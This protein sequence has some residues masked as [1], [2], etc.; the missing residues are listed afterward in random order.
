VAQDWYAELDGVTA[1]PFEVARLRELAAEG[2]LTGETRVRLRDGEWT[3]AARVSGLLDGGEPPAAA[4]ET[5]SRASIA[6]DPSLN[7][8]REW[9]MLSETAKTADVRDPGRDRPLPRRV[10][11]RGGE[12]ADAPPASR[13]VLTLAVAGLALAAAV[14]LGVWALSG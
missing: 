4:A 6:I 8:T 14:A 5:G 12:P 13:T 1:G 9:R 10:A 7:D 2:K 11:A 3:R